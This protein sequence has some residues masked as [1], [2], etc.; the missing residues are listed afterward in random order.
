[1]LKMIVGVDLAKKAIQ[2]CSYTNKKVCS[3]VEMTPKEFACWL[4]TS[5]PATIIFEACGTSNYWK[6]IAT[7]CGHDA[8]LISPK[9]VTSIRQNQK[10]DKNY[11]LA[12]IQAALLPEVSFIQGK[13][14][15]QQ[16]LQSMM[17]LR[18]LS[19]KKKTA[20]KN[21]LIALL[22][23]FNA[24]SNRNGGLKGCLDLVLEDAE[25]GFSD[26]FRKCLSS[27]WDHYSALS[28]TI[29]LYDSCL[30]KELKS[31][32]DCQK[33]MKIEGIGVLNAINLYIVLGCAE[34]GT[35]NQGKDASACI[36]LTPIQHTS[37]G[38]VKH[39]AIGRRVKNTL[40]RSQLITGAMAVVSHVVN[41]PAKTKKEEWLYQFH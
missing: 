4:N 22:S 7:S 12:I 25:N 30:E 26:E 29:D 3:N 32:P 40:I 41:R 6:Q 34:I 23:E 35:F 11:A 36:G 39:G 28:D 38:K 21:Q 10:T 14:A 18:E 31:H 27:A 8:R 5:E 13:S 9:L 33:L 16:Q 15:E 37:G 19:V 20:A 2:V 17:R 24:V 1:M